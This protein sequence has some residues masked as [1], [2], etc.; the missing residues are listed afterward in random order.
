MAVAKQNFIAVRTEL[1]TRG[2]DYLQEY[3][4]GFGSGFACAYK[5]S[6]L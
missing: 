3:P 4:L 2:L 5:E 6:D 1:A